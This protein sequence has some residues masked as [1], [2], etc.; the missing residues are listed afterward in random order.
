MKP[1]KFTDSHR[2]PNGYTS[3]AHTDIRTTFGRH[4]P[5]GPDYRT[6]E[7]YWQALAHDR[8][9]RERFGDLLDRINGDEDLDDQCDPLDPST[10]SSERF[11][12][13]I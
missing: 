12:K 1:P 5:S 6:V 7:Q 13:D 2:Y 9:F 8:R 3:A 11:D 4:Y 10:W